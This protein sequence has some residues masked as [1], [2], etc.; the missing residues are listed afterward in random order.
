MIKTNKGIPVAS[1]FVRIVHR[2]R[3]KYVE[4]TEDQ[5]ISENISVPQ[6]ARWR[7][8]KK[9]KDTVYYVEYRTT[10]NVMI[11]HQKKI[12]DYADYKINCYYIALKDLDI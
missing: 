12:V 11:Y 1:D 2:K 10:D 4:F 6:N 5:M 9:W 7:L 8:Y 3:E